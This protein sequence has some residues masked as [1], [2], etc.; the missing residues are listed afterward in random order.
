MPKKTT[1]ELL[2]DV[3]TYVRASDGTSVGQVATALDEPKTR[4]AA[5]I[6]K[7]KEAGDIKQGGERRFARYASTKDIANKKSLHDRKNAG[8]PNK[9]SDAPK[10]PKK[11]KKKASKPA[12][13]AEKPAKQAPKGNMSDLQLLTVQSDD[14][15]LYIKSAAS[16]ASDIVEMLESKVPEGAVRGAL[17]GVVLDK[18]RDESRRMSVAIA[19]LSKLRQEKGDASEG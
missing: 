12:K 9:D 19:T 1:E 5:A 15:V 7:L 17:A 13:Q 18:M 2:N 6:R 8:G 3:R 11:A 4:I 14:L 10:T 16:V